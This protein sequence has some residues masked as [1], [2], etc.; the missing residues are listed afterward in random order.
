MI[1]CLS[2]F[3][4]SGKDTF[5]KLLV[6]NSQTPFIESPY[7][8]VAFA[9]ELKKS[10]APYI[11]ST[12]GIDIFNCTPEEK[13]KARPILISLGCWARD[14]IS[15]NYWVDKVL[16]QV[17]KNEEQK[18]DSIICD[19]RFKSEILRLK[20]VFGQ[21]KVIGVRVIRTDSD[22]NPPQKE[23]E[24]QPIINKYVDYIVNWKTESNL[25]NLIS[26]IQDFEGWL[27]NLENYKI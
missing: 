14:N 15:E 2:G 21:Q 3:A 18:Y 23:L 16:D 1:I 20:E 25:D 26:H 6:Q 12:L 11:K 27:I 13:E 4:T 8:R 24:N 7:K 10:A 5:Y 22:Y 9:D 19:W 17:R